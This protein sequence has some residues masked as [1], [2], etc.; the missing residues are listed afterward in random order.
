MNPKTLYNICSSF[1]T[2]FFKIVNGSNFYMH[3]QTLA[4]LNFNRHILSVAFTLC[5]VMF[6]APKYYRLQYVSG[7]KLVQT[8]SVGNKRWH[9]SDRETESSVIG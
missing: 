5:D 6:S 3:L 2:S 1:P 8:V 9:K 7:D 4:E